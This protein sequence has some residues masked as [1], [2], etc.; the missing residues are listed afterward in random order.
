MGLKNRRS[1]STG[2]RSKSVSPPSRCPG[3][4]GARS[5]GSGTRCGSG[6]RATQAAAQTTAAAPPG[7]GRRPEAKYTVCLVGAA[8]GIGQPLA[9]LLK[10]NPS[11]A[12]LHLFD[13]AP[14]VGIAADVS[15][16]NTP[17]RVTGFS[18]KDKLKEALSGADIVVSVAGVTIKPGQTRDDVFSINAGIIRGLAEGISESCPNALVAIVSNPVN[19]LVPLVV[20]VL[21]SKNVA[22]CE[23]RVFGVCTLDV[24]RACTFAAEYLGMSASMTDVPV[25]GAHAGKTI[26][27]VWSQAQPPVKFKDNQ[28]RDAYHTKVQEAGIKVLEAKEGKGTATLSM[29]YAAAKFTAA[30][31]SALS[32]VPRY[33]CTYVKSDVT[34]GVTYFSNRIQLGKNGIEKNLGTGPL[35]EDEKARVQACL[36]E[37]KE[38]IEKGEQAARK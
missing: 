25:I 22:N 15:H 27:P 3:S 11:I 5:G 6:T 32:G 29:A 33:E 19:S 10:G 21:K 31:T 34:P 16:I 38:Q 23:K 8:G 24:I 37:L 12:N 7:S 35:D 14:T 18:G 28:E 9:L 4:C 17:A 2:R 20:E 30:L 1:N 36:S 26:I 13:V